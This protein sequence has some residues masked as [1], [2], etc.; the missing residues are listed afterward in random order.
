M[1]DPTCLDATYTDV[2]LEPEMPVITDPVMRQFVKLWRGQTI[3]LLR[4]QDTA[5]GNEQTIPKR[6]R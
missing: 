3:A 2:I 6:V 4:A 5:L 1:N